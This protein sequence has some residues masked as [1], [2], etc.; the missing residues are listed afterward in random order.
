MDRGQYSEAEVSYRKALEFD[1]DFLVGK[2]VLARLTTDLDERL[3]LYDKLINNRSRIDGDERLI[4]DVYTALTHFTNLRDLDAENHPAVLDSTLQLAEKNF[5]EIVHKYPS[6]IYLKAEYIEIL[7]SNHG[8]SAALDS[9]SVLADENQKENVFL[10]GHAASM[11]A[12]L[13]E[14]QA[15]FEKAERL[16]QIMD[17]L[18][19]PKTDAV[20]ADLYFKKG[21]YET[22]HK[23]AARAHEL[24]PGNIDVQRILERLE[25]VNKQ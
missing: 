22:A 3:M 7:N 10:L 9:L 14:Y 25:R 11:H 5:R 2:S 8:A 13:Q 15:A 6:E 1:P 4:L 12:E 23:H 17:G 21:D 16:K 20:Y 18:N 19:Y 24:D